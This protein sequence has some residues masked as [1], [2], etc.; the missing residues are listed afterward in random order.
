I[1][2]VFERHLA[3]GDQAGVD[4][5]IALWER[6]DPGSPHVLEVRAQAALG[7]G[8]YADAGKLFESLL[9]RSRSDAGSLHMPNAGLVYARLLAGDVAGALEHARMAAVPNGEL[10]ITSVLVEPIIYAHALGRGDQALATDW[11]ARVRERMPSGA[12]GGANYWQLAYSMAIIDRLAGRDGGRARWVGVG[13]GA[14]VPKRYR[15]EPQ[16]RILAVLD[17][18]A[19]DDRAALR[20]AAETDADLPAHHIAAALLAEREGRL[21]SAAD[22]L[23]AAN[24][25]SAGGELHCVALAALV[26]IERAAAHPA[27]AD[28]A[29]RHIR[30]PRVP[31]PFCLVAARA[32]R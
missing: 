4:R 27:Q 15:F 18:A 29:C 32:C 22:H 31:S 11:E 26:R 9:D 12:R 21:A 2:H 14:A 23:Q 3:E 30:Q 24:G 5:V 25:A 20:R 8:R 10:P 17:A 28:T 6:I 19:D 7:A 1:Y 13:P 16:A